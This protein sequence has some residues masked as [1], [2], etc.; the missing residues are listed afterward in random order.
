MAHK[1]SQ[2]FPKT[3]I[4]T[5]ISFLSSLRRPPFWQTR[6]GFSYLAI[7]QLEEPTLIGDK[8]LISAVLKLF[9]NKK[10]FQV[11][12]ENRCFL[13]EREGFEPSLGSL[14]LTV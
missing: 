8:I 2:M 4:R 5:P 13:A 14:L 6:V 12:P 3:N 10:G 7:S 1:Q 11:I 9:G